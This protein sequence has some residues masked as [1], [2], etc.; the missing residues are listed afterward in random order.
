MAEPNV[1]EN[2]SVEAI[3]ADLSELEAR[4]RAALETAEEASGEIGRIEARL[5]E[6][7]LDLQA[8]E[9]DAVVEGEG[10][11]DEHA[12][13]SR[14][15]RISHAAATQAERKLAEL[16]REREDAERRVH[17]ERFEELGRTRAELEAQIEMSMTTLVEGLAQLEDHDRR[18]HVEEYG[19]GLGERYQ[20][21]V[22][23]EMLLGWF[24]ATLGGADP[25]YVPLLRH[26]HYEKSLPE[27]DP[28]A[29]SVGA[30]RED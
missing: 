12:K 28:M 14:R 1:T 24:G 19:A 18:K 8:E 2:G 29:H 21:L 7:A 10:L 30:P 11:E 6:I 3:E 13:H 23:M 15:L 9:P 17:R 16:E 20:T 22:V 25:G 4:R 5:E 26:E 27:L